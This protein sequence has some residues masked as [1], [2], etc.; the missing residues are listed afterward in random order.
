MVAGGV[1]RERLGLLYSGQELL[2]LQPE[3]PQN[4]GKSQPFALSLA[5]DYP[6]KHLDD[7]VA[8][9]ARSG[10][11][12]LVVAGEVSEA[13]RVEL[14]ELAGDR[15]RELV[16]L[17]TVSRPNVVWLLKHA[18][19]A[20]SCS[21]VEAFPLTIVE[22]GA[23][24]C[25]LLLSDIPSHREVAGEH[26]QYVPSGN[27]AALSAALRRLPASPKREPWTWGRSWAD[28]AKDLGRVIDTLL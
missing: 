12:Q 23:T 18:A 4:I 2:D 6:H 14:S 9:W 27:V 15:G 11:L 21:T 3:E 13:R 8:G 16:F 28:N 17:G 24:G 10:H 5:N 26:A 20:V 1:R 7:L 22:A 19:I 25:P